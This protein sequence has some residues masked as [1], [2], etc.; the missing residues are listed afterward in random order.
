MSMNVAAAGRLTL[1]L[2]G[3]RGGKSAYA[4]RL[5]HESE[6]VFGREVCYIATAQ[7]LDED[8]TARIARHRTER[9]AHWRTIEEPCQIDEAL[10][11]AHGAG[12]VVVDC[13][14]LFVSN[15]LMRYEDEHECEKFVRSVTRNFL[16]LART[17]EQTI[18]C[19]SNEVGLGVVPEAR[20]GRTFRDLLGRVNQDFAAAAD[21][22]YLLVAGLPLQLKPDSGS[23]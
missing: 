5:A 14:T 6:R 10:R 12:I 7:G 3:A 20:L 21:E 1:L 16:E 18:I 15:W 4:L 8:M 11:Q 9:P 22:V 2:G 17:R 13:L 19:V 23:V